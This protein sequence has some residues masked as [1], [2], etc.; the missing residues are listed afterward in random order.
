M[1][2]SVDLCNRAEMSFEPDLCSTRMKEKDSSDEKNF[3]TLSLSLTADRLDTRV[4]TG[5]CYH[6]P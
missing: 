3:T 4:R 1:Y 5:A 2:R 6:S